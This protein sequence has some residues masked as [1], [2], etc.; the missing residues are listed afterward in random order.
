MIAITIRQR[1]KELFVPAIPAARTTLGRLYTAANKVAC[2]QGHRDV[3][4]EHVLRET[5]LVAQ[6][7]SRQNS[8][9]GP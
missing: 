3:H 9:R 1:E 4:P 6:S 7:L 8:G 2:D 5:L